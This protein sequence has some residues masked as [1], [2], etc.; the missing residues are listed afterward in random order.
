MV[1]AVLG[2]ISCSRGEHMSGVREE[3]HC[4]CRPL[5]WGQVHARQSR[6]DLESWNADLDWWYGGGGR[7]Y[8]IG[9]PPPRGHLGH[10]QG[11]MASP[12]LAFPPGCRPGCPAHSLDD[13]NNNASMQHTFPPHLPSHP[14]L[15]SARFQ[16]TYIAHPFPP[17]LIL[18]LLFIPPTPTLHSQWRG[19]QTTQQQATSLEGM[20]ELPQEVHGTHP[21]HPP[22]FAEAHR[23]PMHS[24][25]H[26]QDTARRT[27]SPAPL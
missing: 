20:P 11:T 7:L 25:R 5:V 2:M 14:L 3:R 12:G 6:V 22:L 24:H 1:S 26:Q 19:I 8:Q 23:H 18:S 10:R 17:C 15:L 27:A 13:D 21:Y 4:R 16:H 9:I